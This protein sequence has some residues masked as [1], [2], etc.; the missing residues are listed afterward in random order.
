MTTI[1]LL[2]FDPD[3]TPR[4]RAVGLAAGY[5]ALAVLVGWGYV[6]LIDATALAG[7]APAGLRYLLVGLLA[8]MTAFVA[9]GA[10]AIVGRAWSWRQD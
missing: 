5:A 3:P 1:R 9:T 2:R 10:A 6:T 4:L 8:I 7:L